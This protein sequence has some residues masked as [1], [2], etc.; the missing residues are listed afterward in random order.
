[1]MFDLFAKSRKEGAIAIESDVED[2]EK[3]P[4]FSRY[5]AFLGIITL[6]TSCATPCAW[7]SPA[8]STRLMWTR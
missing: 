3:S 6:E 5:P 7:R 4:I 8:E 2:P 1:M